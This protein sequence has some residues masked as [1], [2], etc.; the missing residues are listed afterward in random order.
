MCQYDSQAISL[1]YPTFVFE[2]KQL[3]NHMIDTCDRLW[4]LLYCFIS[5]RFTDPHICQAFPFNNTGADV[6]VGE[7]GVYFDLVVVLQVVESQFY[8]A[9]RRAI[10]V[11]L[12]VYKYGMGLMFC[13][14]PRT[15][16]LTYS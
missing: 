11:T 10:V 14:L 15:G 16:V 1:E 7:V 4:K 8:F 9:T 13:Q 12:L 2:H 6:V 5:N 3:V